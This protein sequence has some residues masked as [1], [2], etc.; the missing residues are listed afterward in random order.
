MI[1]GWW[2]EPQN[3]LQISCDIVII[4]S[5]PGGSFA[6]LTLAE[7]GFDVVVLEKGFS[8][9]G[10]RVPKNL[11]IAV[12]DIYSESAFRTADGSPPT[13][14]A[15]GE[16]LGGG[17]VVNSAICF[18][19]PKRSLDDWNERSDNRF[20]D[21]DAYFALQDDI[22]KI[23]NVQETPDALLSG[24]DR[25]HKRGAQVLGWEEGN[26][27]RNTPGCTGCH[28]CNAVCPTGGKNS[29][30]KGILPRAAKAGAKVYTGCKVE[31]VFEDGVMGT[32]L[33]SKRES[34]G[35][36]DIKA[37]K[38]ILSAGSV[39]TPELLL[40]SGF[41]KNNS[42]IGRGLHLHPVISTW[43]MMSTPINKRGATQG[44]FCDQFADDWVLLESNPV[45][46]GAF[47]QALPIYGNEA[48]KIMK[49]ASHFIT[50]GALVKDSSE[51]Q[52]H[53]P[54]NGTSKINY[55]L[56]ETDRRRLVKGLR[57]AAQLYLEG[58]GAEAIV[59]SVFGGQWCRNMSDVDKY[60][61]ADLSVHR[62]IPYSSHCQASCRMGRA[63]DQ[64]G[65]LLGAKNIYVMDSSVL[66]SN[67]GRN[68]QISI[69]TVS[70]LLAEELALQMGGKIKP[71]V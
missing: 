44:H 64:D 17:S 9:Q 61:P 41:D 18:K 2:I 71:L 58:A 66:P 31:G 20:S 48:I 46:G 19:T 10:K 26:I 33:N 55:A 6:A 40:Q 15:G 14:V 47:F 42:Q 7:A 36:F 67:V 60:I 21:T 29:M 16:A 51:G 23:L 45:I 1:S 70:R 4:G 35:T 28:R 39:G 50:T 59:P 52:V 30:D 65:R 54:E 25:I 32:I 24:N 63:C 38:I 5:G 27:W 3:N 62:L 22:F 53:L 57:A 69:M 68:P 34:I 13:P 37:K 49:K 11:R 12:K 56:N 43:G 8:Y